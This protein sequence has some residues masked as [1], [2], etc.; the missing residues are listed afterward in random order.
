MENH[1]QLHTALT[2]SA[3]DSRAANRVFNPP[4]YSLPPPALLSIARPS[5]PLAVRIC[6]S[7]ALELND[8]VHAIE[9]TP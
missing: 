7:P 9:L 2:I 4:V 8:R 1:R 5:R 3:T 6:R